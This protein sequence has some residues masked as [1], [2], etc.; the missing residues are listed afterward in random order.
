MKQSNFL[1]ICLADA[2]Y[3]LLQTKKNNKITI[4]EICQKAGTSRPT[5]YR[6]FYDKEDLIVVKLD[7][8]I[9]TEYSFYF[10][11]TIVTDE[12]MLNFILYIVQKNPIFFSTLK[13]QDLLHY[14]HITFA[15][16]F[17]KE[18]DKIKSL[19]FKNALLSHGLEGVISYWIEDDFETDKTQIVD[20]ILKALR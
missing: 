8:I 5:F 16:Y 11:K 9:F 14:F 17:F 12:Q 10:Q 2:Y 6:H 15:K 19:M 1:K 20:I 7:E 3:Q 18:Q 13:E 4:N